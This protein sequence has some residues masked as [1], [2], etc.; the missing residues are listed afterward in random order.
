[1]KTDDYNT[2]VEVNIDMTKYVGN[3]IGEFPVN[4]DKYQAVTIPSSNNLFKVD[5]SNPEAFK[6]FFAREFREI[7]VQPRTSASEGYRAHCTRVGQD[8]ATV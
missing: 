5:G 6:T 1:M 7:R 8:N 2:R 4:I 3:S